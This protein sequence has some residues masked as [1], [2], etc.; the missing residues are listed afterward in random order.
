M[1][2]FLDSLS[3]SLFGIL[4]VFLALV[5]L[6]AMIFIISRALSFGAKRQASVLAAKAAAPA[7]KETPAAPAPAAPAPEPAKELY[8]GPMEVRLFDVDEKTAAMIMAIVCDASDI[9]AN[10]LYF[11][12]IKALD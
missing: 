8:S 2:D 6:I 7:T 9:P 4:V 1:S 10:E 3:T 11:K 12:S 5:S